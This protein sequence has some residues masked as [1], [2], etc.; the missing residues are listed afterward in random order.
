MFSAISMHMF[1]YLRYFCLFPGR[2]ARN[3]LDMVI[4]SENNGVSKH[5]GRIANA[6]YEWEGR[7]AD[8]LGLSVVDVA[9]IKLKHPSNLKLQTYVLYMY[10]Y[11]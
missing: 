9:E 1:L 11:V 3:Q 10:I 5:L 6:M 7:I 4:D 8:E 2:P